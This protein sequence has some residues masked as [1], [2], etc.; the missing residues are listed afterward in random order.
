LGAV[1]IAAAVVA[2][3]GAC[4]GGGAAGGGDQL[5]LGQRYFRQTCATCHGMNGEGI[6]RLGKPLAGNEL[7]VVSSTSALIEL[8]AAGRPATHPDNTRGVA[9][10]PRGGN[11]SL[12][13]ED[14]AAI[15]AYL[16]TL[17]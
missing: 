1:A 9:M 11:P 12:T 17:N 15:V 8:L 7:V 13:D 14:L 16:R 4:G 10:P 5:A 6:D 2:A 3:T